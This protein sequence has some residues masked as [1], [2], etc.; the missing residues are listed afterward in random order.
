MSKIRSSR[1]PAHLARLVLSN[2]SQQGISPPRNRTMVSLLEILHFASLHTDEQRSCRCTVNYI[3][4]HDGRSNSDG[5]NSSWSTIPFHEP[6]PLTIRSLVKLAEAADPAVSSLAVFEDDHGALVIWGMVDQE[7]RFG[8]HM[9]LDPTTTPQRPGLFQATISGVGIVSVYKNYALLGSLEQDKLIASYHD[10]LWQGPVHKRLK[11]NLNRMLK[12]IPAAARRAAPVNDIAQVEAE[13]FVRWQNAICRLLLNIQQ[14]GHGGGVL[15]T[16]CPA[17]RLDVKYPLRYQRLPRAL[18]GLAKHQLLK[19]HTAESISL[20]CQTPDDVVPCDLHHDAIAYHSTLQAHKREAFGC[21]RFMSSLSRVDGFVLL[22][23][24]LVVHGFGV[25][26][27]SDSDR[28]TVYVAADARATPR[29]LREARMSQYGTRHRAMMRYCDA[30][31]DA[32][33]LVISQDGDIRATMKVKDRLILWENINLQIGFRS[34]SLGAPLLDAE[35]MMDLFRL[36]MET[37]VNPGEA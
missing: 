9:S 20:H 32:L 13:L 3:D 36:W 2:L 33:G 23:T 11:D 17:D 15:I 24:N 29:L 30:N 16:P 26:T 1:Y 4:P 21:V 10:V 25:E 7:L 28:A 12:K 6:L 37:L 34:E 27:R 18:L 14:H 31:P 5:A 19:Q 35:P 22:D 8:D